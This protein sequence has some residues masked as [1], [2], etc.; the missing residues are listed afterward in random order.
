M[1]FGIRAIQS[2]VY[3]LVHPLHT[4]IYRSHLMRCIHLRK[5]FVKAGVLVWGTESVEGRLN[6]HVLK[7]RYTILV[8]CENWC[9][10][11]GICYVNLDVGR[12]LV[13]DVSVLDKDRQVEDWVQ[14]RIKI[15]RLKIFFRFSLNQTFLFRQSLFACLFQ[16]R[17]VTSLWLPDYNYLLSLCIY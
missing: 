10:V 16:R 12:V 3:L 13:T 1:Y 7:D 9:V 8:W 11:I 2:E 17:L 5:L 6:C 15:Y 4:N 14:K